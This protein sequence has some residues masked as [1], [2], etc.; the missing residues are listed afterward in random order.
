MNPTENLKQIREKIVLFS[1]QAKEGHIPS[2]LSILDLLW[3]LYDS[4]LK[5]RPFDE[6]RDVFIMS[7]G[8]ASIGLYSVLAH[9]G[10]ID[11]NSLSS[12]A[13][14]NSMLG[15]HPD[16]NK[17]PFVEASTGS[18]GHGMPI[19]VGVALAKKI[20]KLNGSAYALVGDGEC[21]EGSIWESSLLAAEHQLNN[22]CCIVDHNHTTD[23]ALS[24]DS[25]A[26]KFKA[27]GWEVIE[28]DGHDHRQILDAFSYFSNRKNSKPFCIVANTTKG[29][30]IK[31][32]ENTPEWHHK[33]PNEEEL[34]LLLGEIHA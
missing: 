1:T 17:V 15:G 28:I 19:A 7:K 32:M 31:T 18:L 5:L 24:I 34:E 6:N 8:H 33:T 10:L 22:L 14:F 29:F 13:S 12:F 2:A 4:V 21:N 11:G 25:V 16:R 20:S 23:R 3:C 30:G 27:F 9:K 26:D